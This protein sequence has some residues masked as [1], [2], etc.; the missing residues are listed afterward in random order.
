[1]HRGGV[2]D[3]DAG[4]APAVP[5]GRDELGVD[6]LVREYEE[7]R[8]AV[9]LPLAEPVEGLVGQ[10]VGR[11][12]FEGPLLAVDVERGVDVAA[13]AAEA[14]PAVEARLRPGARLGHVALAYR[15]R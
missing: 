10:D 8:R 6:G 2:R 14:H 9:A 7:E 13:L 5:L 15:G 4:V 3:V 11:V 1:C 12:A